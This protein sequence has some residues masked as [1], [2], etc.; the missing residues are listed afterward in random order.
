MI[1]RV[2]ALRPLYAGQVAQAAQ[3]F[4]GLSEKEGQEVADAFA[5]N[6]PVK[7]TGPIDRELLADFVHYL[8]QC[9]YLWPK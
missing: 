4:F 8:D 9:G 6:K 1:E 7:L 3:R 2:I 5:H